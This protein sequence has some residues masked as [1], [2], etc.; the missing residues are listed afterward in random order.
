MDILD[1]FGI[2]QL[3][4]WGNKIFGVNKS[5]YHS[6]Q[7]KPVD[8]SWTPKT[9]DQF[10]GN[11]SAKNL[12]RLNLKKIK[13]IM[14]VHFLITASGKGVGKSTLAKIIS[15]ELNV[16]ISWYVGG[17]FTM[18]NLKEFLV[19]NQ[20]LRNNIS[21]LF[22]DEAHNLGQSKTLNPEILY[23]IFEN[24]VLPMGNNPK[25]RPFIC[26][27]ATNKRSE[28]QKKFS[29]LCDRCGADI[30]L[31]D[32]IPEEIVTIL[33][34]FNDKVYR[35][36]IEE[37]VYQKIANN[38]RGVPRI[39]LNFLSD[40]II[41][42]DIQQVLD[43]H[44]IVINGLTKTDFLILKNLVEVGKPCGIEGLAMLAGVTREDFSMMENYLVRMGYL[45]RTPRGRL[46]TR[47]SEQLL[48]GLK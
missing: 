5:Q 34:Q 31:D 33:K 48:Q 47:K 17:S 4:E 25:I 28:L 10:I 12:V 1:I 26:I 3:M 21:I 24:F 8:Y 6:E 41:T 9:L 38:T 44:R 32:Y 16:P 22:I 40:F 30:I 11:E 43:Y 13:E 35:L 42:Q 37:I 19:T 7:I 45:I 2:T 29:P 27:L 36:N 46:A 20:D 14:P 23:P 15:Y 39:A 18:D